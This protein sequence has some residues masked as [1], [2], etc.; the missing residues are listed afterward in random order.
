MSVSI[1]V[2]IVKIPVSDIEK[3]LVFYRDTLGLEEEFTAP[4]YGWAQLRSGNL[5]LALYVPGMGGGNSKAG[6]TDCLHFA[7][8]DAEGFR[9]QLAKA[10][11]DPDRHQY[12]GNDGTSYFELE[13][14]DGNICKVM[15]SPAQE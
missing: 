3:A 7:I 1:A 14:P 12:S 5:P 8:S 4:E 2:Q 15:F 11:I 6:E 9:S 13:D 10:N